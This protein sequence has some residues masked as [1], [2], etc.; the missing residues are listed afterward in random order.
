[1]DRPVPFGGWRWAQ[2]RP[3]PSNVNGGG[4]RPK[5]PV[6]FSVGEGRSDGPWFLVGGKV[7][8]VR[9]RSMSPGPMPSS[10]VGG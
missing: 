9:V 8:G 2:G 3:G 5:R 1:M 10:G 6:P 7:S 4:A